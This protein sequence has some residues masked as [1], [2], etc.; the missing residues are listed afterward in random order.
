MDTHD[1]IRGNRISSEAPEKTPGTPV[2]IPN[3]RI[4]SKNRLT[5]FPEKRILLYCK[6][7]STWGRNGFDRDVEQG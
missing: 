1:R 7:S 2:S 5:F 4:F 6:S 3:T